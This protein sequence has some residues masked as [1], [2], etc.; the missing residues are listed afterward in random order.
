LLLLALSLPVQLPLLAASLRPAASLRRLLFSSSFSSAHLAANAALFQKGK[1][2]KVLRALVCHFPLA[3]EKEEESV[4]LA[5]KV[6]ASLRKRKEVRALGR[7][8]SVDVPLN[9]CFLFF[10]I[11]LLT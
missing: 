10:F 7:R 1:K 9:L 3:T 11:F 6:A 2:G 4:S 8:P 5:P